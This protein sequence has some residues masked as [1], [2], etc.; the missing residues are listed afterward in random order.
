MKRWAKRVIA[1]SVLGTSAARAGD[2]PKLEPPA[3]PTRSEVQGTAN[4]PPGLAE[5]PPVLEGPTVTVPPIEALA[6]IYRPAAPPTPGL[7]APRAMTGDRQAALPPAL[8]G[9]G[10]LT[11]EAVPD[12][13]DFDVKPLAKPVERRE[14]V[15]SPPRRIDPEPRRRGFFGLFRSEPRVEPAPVER[16]EKKASQPT[17]RSDPAADTALRQKV[18][19]QADRALGRH[20][21]DLDVRVMDQKVVIRAKADF[22]WNKRG[23]RKTLGT[24]PAIRGHE[25][26]I[27]VD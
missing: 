15:D 5:A 2:G 16:R 21:R 14:R 25:A 26:T 20:V 17:S 12:P 19:A 13:S 22:F 7:L 23:I 18:E 27:E 8:E 10:T 6:P 24:L 3:R 9:P 11:L 1:I 4:L